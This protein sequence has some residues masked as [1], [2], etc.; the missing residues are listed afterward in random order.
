M[1][2][3]AHIEQGNFV[4]TM[5]PSLRC[6]LN[7]PHCYLSKEQRQSSE[8]MSPE[9]L[10]MVCR[11][12]DE[13][14]QEAG[15]GEKTV[16]AYWYGGEPLKYPKEYLRA[17]M[18]SFDEVFT[19]EKGYL[20]KHV[21]LSSLI[22]TDPDRFQLLKSKKTELQTSFDGLM[23]GASYLKHWEQGVKQAQAAGLEVSTLS[24]IN[25]EML[26]EGPTKIL[27]YLTKMGF[28]TSGFLPFMLNAENEGKAYDQFAPKMAD[29]SEF[30]CEL[31]DHWVAM[32]RDGMSPPEIGPARFILEQQSRGGLSNIAGQTL[33]LMP[34]GD[35]SLPD[36]R[37]GWFE[38][39]RPFGN[40]HKQSFREVLQSTERRDYL[41]RQ[42][43]K[44]RNPECLSCPH[45]D[46]CLMEFW[47]E[48]RP[49]DDCFGARRFVEHV[50]ALSED[51]EINQWLTCGGSWMC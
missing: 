33:F 26:R 5:M 27:D 4:F 17:L 25:H 1:M 48:N 10:A 38:Y 20:A 45:G 37:D 13:F 28:A 46:K 15:I 43:T 40:M 32:K 41:R 22:K 50:L 30:M 35:F 44:N 39:L 36:Y 14:Y 49:G 6:P 31:L 2:Q 51:D 16:V 9:T 18:D 21:V 12:V 29:F 11:K 42:A 19:P 34:N 24:V 8:I 7:C 3:A 23:R 47:K